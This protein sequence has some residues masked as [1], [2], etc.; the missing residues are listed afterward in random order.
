MVGKRCEDHGR[1]R[2]WANS[3]RIVGEG[4]G[5]RTLPGSSAGAMVGE[6]CQGSWAGAMVGE[7]YEDH[8]RGQWWANCLRIVGG[9]DGGQPFQD[10]GRERWWANC[11]RIL[12]ESD[13]ERTV[14]GSWTRAM[15]SELC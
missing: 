2:W 13:G 12:D 10:R 15:V 6:L 8:G 7:L 3:A 11:V 9:R 4:D 1:G 14:S 5:G